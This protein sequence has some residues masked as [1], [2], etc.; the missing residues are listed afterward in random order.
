[1]KEEG[2]WDSYPHTPKQKNLKEI[3]KRLNIDK[4]ALYWRKRAKIKL[5]RDGQC[6]LCDTKQGNIGKQRQKVL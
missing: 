1:M 3:R 5:I 2:V 4:I 6:G